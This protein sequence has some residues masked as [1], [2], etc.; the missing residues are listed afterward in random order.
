MKEPY[1]V[2]GNYTGQYIEE[3]LFQKNDL[4]IC[5]YIKV[6]KAAHHGKTGDFFCDAFLLYFSCNLIH[7]GTAANGIVNQ[8]QVFVLYCFIYRKGML[9]VVDPLFYF[10]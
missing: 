8:Q 3:R 5:N 9:S 10:A 7:G 2:I 1:F 4:H 6:F